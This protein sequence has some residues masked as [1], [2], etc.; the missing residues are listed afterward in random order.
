MKT[1]NEISREL[2]KA[3]KEVEI[4]TNNKLTFRGKSLNPYPLG[5]WLCLCF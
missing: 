5:I 3:N 1:A 4:I 2:I